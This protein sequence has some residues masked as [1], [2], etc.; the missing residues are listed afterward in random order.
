MK[1]KVLITDTL[2]KINHQKLDTMHVVPFTFTDMTVFKDCGGNKHSM[3]SQMMTS[4]R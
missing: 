4:V 1:G 2:I 3:Y